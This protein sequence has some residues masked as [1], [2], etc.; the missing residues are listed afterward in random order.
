MPT[1]R[2]SAFKNNSKAKTLVDQRSKHRVELRRQRR[3]STL[4]AKRRLYS[5][6]M[7]REIIDSVDAEELAEV[8]MIGDIQDPHGLEHKEMDDIL[9]TVQSVD[10]DGDLA[11]AAISRILP[12][13]DW[14]EDP[15]KYDAVQMLH[16]MASQIGSSKMFNLL[17][18][19]NVLPSLT[20]LIF[21]GSHASQVATTQLL[22]ELAVT[23]TADQLNALRATGIL[24]ALVIMLTCR[25]NEAVFS[26]LNIFKVL[27]KHGANDSSLMDILMASSFRSDLERLY[28][29]ENEHISGNALELLNAVDRYENEC[30][31][32]MGDEDNNNG[33]VMSGKFVF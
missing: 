1:Q 33:P 29:M 31:E 24:P 9:S 27:M 7:I 6:D 3:E 18:A 8:E 28:G 15:V 26:A 32:E 11:V 2:K 22:K 14:V 5:E 13:L 30:A 20:E 21:M 19:S 17:I 10:G 16:A 4:D 25:D 12:L 23:G